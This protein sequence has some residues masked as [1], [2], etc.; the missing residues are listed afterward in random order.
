MPTLIAPSATL[1][2]DADMEKLRRESVTGWLRGNDPRRLT[3]TFHFG[4]EESRPVVAGA[5]EGAIAL[6]IGAPI[7]GPREL[8]AVDRLALAGFSFRDTKRHIHTQTIALWLVMPKEIDWAMRLYYAAWNAYLTSQ[9]LAIWQPWQENG[10][11]PITALRRMRERL[12][13]EAVGVLTRL[14]LIEFLKHLDI[15]AAEW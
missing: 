12:L 2:T 5:L 10:I 14:E 13:Q 11:L 4:P 8:V 1:V 7:V 6:Y 9:S 3:P 15:L